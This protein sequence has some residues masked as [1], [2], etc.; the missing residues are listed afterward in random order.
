MRGTKVFLSFADRCFVACLSAR[1]GSRP[2]HMFVCRK[3]DLNSPIFVQSHSRSWRN[4][5]VIFRQAILN[6][7]AAIIRRV[8]FPPFL[9]SAYLGSRSDVSSTI[10]AA[11]E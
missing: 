4:K 10:A 5:N 9:V 1:E 8:K 2:P 3:K 11:A 6:D 7:F